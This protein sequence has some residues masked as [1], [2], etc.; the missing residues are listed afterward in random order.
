[1]RGA[2]KGEI[3]GKMAG[4]GRKGLARLR[5]KGKRSFRCSKGEKRGTGERRGAAA[6]EDWFRCGRTAP[7]SFIKKEEKRKDDRLAKEKDGATKAC[8]GAREE[9]KR[10][11]DG[12]KGGFA[13]KRR[14]PRRW[15]SE[16]EGPVRV[17]DEKG[18]K[19]KIRASPGIRRRGNR[20]PR[21]VSEKSL[22]A[23]EKHS[24]RSA[25][26]GKGKVSP[27]GKM[28]AFSATR[29]KGGRKNR[30]ARASEGEERDGVERE[31][32]ES[33]R[34]FTISESRIVEGEGE[35]RS[36]GVQGAR[37]KV[38]FGNKEGKKK[39]AWSVRAREWR[40]S[41][42]GRKGGKKN[43]GVLEK[44]G[45]SQKQETGGGKS[46]MPAREGKGK[47]DLSTTTTRE[48]TFGNL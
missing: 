1:M 5:K 8:G 22:Q 27:A 12:L 36:R 30:V 11:Q 29:R 45:R 38:H 47:K 17:P 46:E 42:N 26:W 32:K 41:R 25:G 20:L 34:E 21:R 9:G 3:I 35:S 37:K 18:G 23:K 31:R 16:K 4:D 10:S 2:K 48:D 13:G 33:G 15:R 40:Y 44:K 14:V 7:G 43:V 24:G 19:E 6:S 28:R 39:A